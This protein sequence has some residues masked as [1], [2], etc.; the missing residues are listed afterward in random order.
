MRSLIPFTNHQSASMINN[1]KHELYI[2]LASL[3][4][5]YSTAKVEKDDMVRNSGGT[6]LLSVGMTRGEVLAWHSH[7][8]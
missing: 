7:C 8:L 3:P 5:I 1:R 6:L 2:C 4:K